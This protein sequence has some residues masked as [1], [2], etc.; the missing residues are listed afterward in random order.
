MVDD[1]EGIRY[2]IKRHLE[3]EGYEVHTAEDGVSGLERYVGDSWDVVLTD[4]NMPR[5]GGD[6]LAAAIKRIDPRAP[7]IL[8]TNYADHAPAP[9]P[10]ESLFELTIRKPFHGETIL[11]A[12]TALCTA[13]EDG[14]DD[15]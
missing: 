15:C 14:A 2:L 11:A 1:D 3:P 6:A 8:V 12:V 4:R 7:I 9:V 5:M 13:R 10:S